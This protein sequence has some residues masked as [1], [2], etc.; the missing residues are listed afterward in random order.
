MRAL[1]ATD[2][3]PSHAAD[4]LQ[5]NQTSSI[6]RSA[7]QMAVTVDTQVP[8]G[9]LKLALASDCKEE[10]VAGETDSLFQCTLFLIVPNA[11]RRTKPAARPGNH[12]VPALRISFRAEDGSVMRADWCV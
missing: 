10:C 9:A 3:N 7:G 1:A 11:N 8:G 5:L 2:T 6:K 4:L 12:I